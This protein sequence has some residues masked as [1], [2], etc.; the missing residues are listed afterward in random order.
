MNNMEHF[1]QRARRVLTLADEAAAQLQQPVIGSEHVL[2]GLLREVRGVASRVLHDLGVEQKRVIE[3]IKEVMPEVQSTGESQSH[4]LSAETKQV[5]ELAIEEA[6]LLEQRYIGTEHLL[7]GLVRQEE[8]MA[9]RILKRFDISPEQVRQQTKQALETDPMPKPEPSQKV[10]P[11]I[12][13]NDETIPTAF[14]ATGSPHM[15][16]A[17]VSKILAM[18]S[19]NKLTSDQAGELLRALQLDIHPLI[20]FNKDQ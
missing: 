17:I 8:S 14:P 20:T 15:T 6:R 9:V 3:F 5:L 4:E 2:L 12:R 16:M 1:T 10:E 18:V 11:M 7:L 19:E 13:E